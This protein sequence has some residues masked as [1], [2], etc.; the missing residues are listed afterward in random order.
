M[1][2]FSNGKKSFS[3]TRA[4]LKTAIVYG[5]FGV[6]WIRFS[7]LLLDYTIDDAR[8]MTTV[9]TYKGWFFILVTAALL[10]LLVRRNLLSQKAFESSLRASNARLDGMFRVA[11]GVAFILSKKR[12]GLH[13]VEAV[14]PGAVRMFGLEYSDIGRPVHGL[15]VP[16]SLLVSAAGKGTG[17]DGMT[18]IL[19]T[20]HQ[21][22]EKALLGRTLTL[23]PEEDGTEV[24]LSVALDVTE[25]RQMAR[26]LEAAHGVIKGILDAVSSIVICVDER[27]GVLHWNAAAQACTGLD[28]A[29]VKGRPL[30]SAFPFLQPRL[31]EISRAVAEK[32]SLAFQMRPSADV[33]LMQ[34]GNAETRGAGGPIFYEVQVFPLTHEGGGGVI[35]VDDITE[36]V[37]VQ[38]VLVQTEKVM[39][40]GGLAA[41]MAHEIN[42]P[43]GAVMQGAQNVRRRLSSDLPANREAAAEVGCDLEALDRYVRQRN[44]DRMLDGVVEAGRRAADIVTNM[45]DYARTADFSH[46][47]VHVDQL[48]DKALGLV[49]NDYSIEKGY[50]FRMIRVVREYGK[51]LP[52]VSCS[53]IGIEQVVVNLLRNA[54]QAMFTYEGGE[55][56]KPEIRIRTYVGDDR[57]VI[58]VQDNGPGMTGAQ[59][60][61][62][63]E[64]FFTTKPSGEGT[65]LGLSVAHY[66]ITSVHRG[67]FV[68]ESEPGKGALFRIS[69]PLQRSPELG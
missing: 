33:C 35:R 32:R 23:E 56:W 5:V 54:A 30:N 38:D 67:E 13:F 16:D 11:G 25:R 4:A 10:F 49:D 44:L 19:F 15:P 2:V 60:K 40:V 1:R 14:S 31:N 7:D 55:G 47:G 34:N 17:L 58:E 42:N 36:R 41:G 48:L 68:L 29:Q 43:L 8:T 39:S 62:A 51:D 20:T 69:L 65:G 9:Q 27:M 61:R 45:L 59:Q 18:E 3:I 52:M 53:R 64:P 66:I 37:R 12:G 21:G 57:V 46:S 63:F 6:L 26:E 28:M 24:L 22:Q 50:D